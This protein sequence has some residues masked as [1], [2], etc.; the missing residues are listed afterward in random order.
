MHQ[1]GADETARREVPRQRAARVPRLSEAE[2]VQGAPGQS[3]KFTEARPLGGTWALDALWTRLGFG[4]AMR[5]LLAGNGLDESAERVL[6]AMVANRALAPSSALAAARWATEDVSIAGLPSATENA[7][8]QLMDWLPGIEDSLE[9]EVFERVSAMP[10]R[11]IDRVFFGI[12]AISPGGG[13]DAEPAIHGELVLGDSGSADADR[14]TAWLRA[15]GKH[16]E[17][18]G[19][20]PR[21]VIGMAVTRDGFPLRT[22]CWEPHT[23]ER[24]LIGEVR[25]DLRCWGSS[26]VIWVCGQGSMSAAGRRY[27][28]DSGNCVIGEGLRPGSAEAAAAVSRRGRYRDVAGNLKVKEVRS[29]AGERL[30]FCHEPGR[31]ERDASRRAWTLDRLSELITYADTLGKDGRAE[32]RGRIAARPGLN[33]YVRVT[34]GG[35]LRI[36]VKSVRAEEHLDGK[37]LL[38]AATPELTAEEIALGYTRMLDTEHRL[39]AMNQFLEPRHDYHW[40]DKR[41]RAHVLL[42]WLALVL[43]HVA[44]NACH[45]GWPML[46]RELD[47]IAI[48]TFTGS[49]GTFRQRTEVTDTQQRIFAQLGIDPPPLMPRLALPER[50]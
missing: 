40:A 31:A 45:T 46:R 7:C 48:G 37:F 33:R 50:S 34:S 22:W 23:A 44:E 20:P 28:R 35:R 9:R 26:Q 8:R 41:V 4:A 1:S 36:R 29:G 11:D 27:L 5:R 47:R 21:A 13:Q 14:G 17:H 25:E 3:L 15:Y 18:G 42:C 39:R 32:V 24:A 30:I 16:A 12:T 6:F 43:V 38:R 10:N 2:G 49:V 19:Y